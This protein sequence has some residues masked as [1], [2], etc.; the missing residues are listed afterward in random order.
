MP[1]LLLHPRVESMQRPSELTPYAVRCSLLTLS[2][3]QILLSCP[4]PRSQPLPIR[5][6]I[7]R[8]HVCLTR[9]HRR[10]TSKSVS[11][12]YPCCRCRQHMACLW[13]TLLMEAGRDVEAATL[14]GHG[15]IRVHGGYTGDRLPSICPS[16]DSKPASVW[17]Y[18]EIY[19]SW[20]RCR[21]S[22]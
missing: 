1:G 3:R 19:D 13:A 7:Q 22:A 2:L 8:Y 16:V 9:L 11:R 17:L 21:M 6:A 5:P 18:M 4:F 10:S 15:V 12:W 20:M 14:D